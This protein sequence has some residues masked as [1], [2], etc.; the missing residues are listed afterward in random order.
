VARD[1]AYRFDRGSPL[2][3]AGP[4]GG[5]AGVEE[6]VLRLGLARPNMVGLAAG[7]A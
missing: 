4:R 3:F 7:P 2:D 5:R 1:G 6:A